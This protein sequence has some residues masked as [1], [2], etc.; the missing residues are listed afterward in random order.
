MNDAVLIWDW[1]GTLLDD[2]SFCVDSINGLLEKRNFEK[3]TADDYRRKFTFPVKDYYR[4]L[5]LLDEES[6]EDVGTE[7]IVKYFKGIRSC[8]LKEDTADVLKHFHDNG[9]RQYILSAMQHDML[10]DLVG[11]Y[12]I[13]HYFEEIRG[14]DDHYAS[15]KKGAAEKLR[16]DLGSD[17]VWFIGDTVHDYEI[18]SVFK[19]RSILL[20]GG[21]QSNERLA[22]CDGALVLDDIKAVCDCIKV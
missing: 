16:D 21:H 2:V 19:G 5:G 14:T 7:F 11:N 1:N 3:I 17:N 8:P 10:V 13:G 12:D 20:K 4:D 18:S 6:Y 9:V 22:T 15:G